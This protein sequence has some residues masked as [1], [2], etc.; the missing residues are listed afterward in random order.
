[1]AWSTFWGAVFAEEMRCRLRVNSPKPMCR[2]SRR[3]GPPFLS[4]PA[5]VLLSPGMA[6]AYFFVS[7]FSVLLSSFAS[8]VMRVQAS[9]FE[10]TSNC[11]LSKNLE[12]K[13]LK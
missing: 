2:G 12:E 3:A 1:M 9:C 5:G 10:S 11:R 4:A 13:K 6:P 7:L 8:C